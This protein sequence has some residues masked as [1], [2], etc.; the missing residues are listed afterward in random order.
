MLTDLEVFAIRAQGLPAA[1]RALC[2]PELDKVTKRDPKT[3]D[4]DRFE[5]L[6]EDS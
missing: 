3:D 5:P 6:K 4:D 2:Y 1:L